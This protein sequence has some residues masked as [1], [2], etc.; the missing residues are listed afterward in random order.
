MLINSTASRIF[1][2]NWSSIAI[3]IFICLGAALNTNVISII[4]AYAKNRVIGSEQDIP[5][6]IREDMQF[7]KKRT[8][9]KIVIMGR[10]T[11][12]SIPDKYRPFPDRQSYI[13]TRDESYEVD[14]PNVTVFT[15]F[16]KALYVA[17]LTAGDDEIMIAGGAQIYKLA[18]PYADR[19][20][21]TILAD[22]FTGDAYFPILSEDEW[23]HT[24]SIED[25]WDENLDLFYRRFVYQRKREQ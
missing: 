24:D 12:E 14:H 2:L 17:Q 25:F 23:H 13:L 9:G 8:T 19:V 15:D 7:F 20:Y 10:K 21:A 16:K 5:W 22:D 6:Y 4:V 1:V 18:M 11:Y 3:L